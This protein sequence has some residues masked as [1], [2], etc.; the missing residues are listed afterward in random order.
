MTR[1]LDDVPKRGSIC[2][3]VGGVGFYT[4]LIDVAEENSRFWIYSVMKMVSFSFLSFFI[5][6]SPYLG[7]FYL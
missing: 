7:R 6:D 3:E 1:I 5:A 2:G 4:M